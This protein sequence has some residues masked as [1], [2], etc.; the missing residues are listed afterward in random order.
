MTYKVQFT[1]ILKIFGGGQEPPLTPHNS[2]TGGDDTVLYT[3]HD[4]GRGGDDTVL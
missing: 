4:G 2:A 1:C 3:D